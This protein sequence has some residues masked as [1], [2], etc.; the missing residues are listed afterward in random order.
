MMRCLTIIPITL[1][2]AACCTQA[3]QPRNVAKLSD[4]ELINVAVSAASIPL[5]Q[6]PRLK[7]EVRKQSWGWEIILPTVV[8][9]DPVMYVDISRYGDVLCVRSEPDIEACL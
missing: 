4:T 1:T 8:T 3:V 7:A 5:S 2:L 9:D 6:V